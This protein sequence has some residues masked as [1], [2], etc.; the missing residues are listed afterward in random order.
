VELRACLSVFAEMQRTDCNLSPVFCAWREVRLYTK[1][2]RAGGSVTLFKSCIF[3]FN[4]V[5]KSDASRD[6]F[7]NEKHAWES[8]QKYGGPTRK[9]AWQLIT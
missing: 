3:F 4:Q 1:I 6:E 9:S 5:K 8:E 7:H 2:Q